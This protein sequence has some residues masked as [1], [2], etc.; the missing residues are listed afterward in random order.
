MSFTP[1]TRLGP[2]EIQSRLGIGGMGEVYQPRDTRLQRLVALKVLRTDRD[3]DPAGQLRLLREARSASALHHSH[4]VAI[5]DILT[6]DGALVL[7]WS[8][9][10]AKV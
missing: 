8:M 3:I 9:S 7:S 4:I 5:H 10:P 1:A 2:Y 6:E